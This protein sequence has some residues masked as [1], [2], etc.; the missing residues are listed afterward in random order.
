MRL[1]ETVQREMK[2]TSGKIEAFKSTFGSKQ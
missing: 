2:L 1:I